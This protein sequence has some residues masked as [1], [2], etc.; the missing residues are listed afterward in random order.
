MAKE[1][2]F[3]KQP[4]HPELTSRQEKLAPP[5]L[6]EK[7][8]PYKVEALLDKG[9]M[10]FLYLGSHPE[11]HEPLTIKVLSQKFISNPEV[12]QRFLNE[13]EIISMTNHP[14]IIKMFGHG[15]WEGGLYIA[16][17]YVEG[18][19][20]R[21]YILQTP[22]SLK[23]ALGIIID[24][25]YAL[26]HL[27]THGVIHRDLKPENILVTECGAIKVI[28]FGIAQLLTEKMTPNAPP[29]QKLIGTPIYISPEQKENPE[30]VS[31]PS[32]IYSLG[33]ISYELILGKLSHGYIH[34]SLMP[35]GMQPIL[36]KCLRPRPEDRYQDIVD[37]ITDVSGYLNSPFQ[38][39]DR[40]L[41]DKLSELSEELRHVQMTLVPS[42][43]PEWLE[44]EIGIASHKGLNV[45]GVYYDFFQVAEDSYGIIMAE[46]PAEGAKGYIAT[47]TFRGMVRALYQQTKKPI[48][49]VSVLND[50]VF[51]DQSGPIFNLNYIILNPKGNLL[52]Y[53]SCGYGTLWHIPTGEDTPK[54]CSAQHLPLGINSKMEF[55]EI[56]TPWNVG[57]ILLL[58]TFASFKQPEEERGWGFNENDLV[59]AI[60]D[61]SKYPPQQQVDNI[62]RKTRISSGEKIKDTSLTLICIKRIS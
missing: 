49:L 34:I 14:N 28:D 4:T 13:A 17:E 23:R 22:L 37:F 1:E 15:E 18:I 16:M 43:P 59:K 12:V 30:T 47:A 50:L 60:H 53:V 57:D 20:L 35:K 48:E 24:I 29:K 21:K 31:Y 39:K 25:A 51:K 36:Q 8:G 41:G 11:T 54:K 46:S 61:N 9:G 45:S 55:E 5:E 62:M 26:C 56:S 3:Y 44:V 52:T 6:P 27:H 42:H 32:D 40:I 10:S 38:K 19:S 58:N 2:N 33:I 7:I